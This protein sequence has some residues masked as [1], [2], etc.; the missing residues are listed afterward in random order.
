MSKNLPLSLGEKTGYGLG[1]FG[2]GLLFHTTSIYLLI[3]YTDV[4]GISAI[5][6]S[7]LFLVAR[8]WDAINDPIVGGIVDRTRS[9]WG[10]FRPYL[11]FGPIPLG[12]AGVLCFTV[13]DL[14]DVGKLIYAYVTY[15]TFGM[16][17]TLVAVPYSALTSSITMDSAERGALSGL[18]AMFTLMAGMLVA[19]L[20]LLVTAFGGEDTAGGYQKSIMLFSALM[21][22]CLFVTFYTTKERYSAPPQ[23]QAISLAEIISILKT[24]RPLQI[25][26]LAFVVSFGNMSI[27]GSVGTYFFTYNLGRPDLIPVFMLINVSTVFVG[28]LICQLVQKKLEKKQI[29]ILGTLIGMIRPLSMYFPDINIIL[30]GSVIGGIGQGFA[31]AV[32]WAFVADTIEYGQYKTGQ[33]NEGMTYA[34]V[35][36]FMKMGGALGAMIPGFVLNYTGYVP[37]VE[38]TELTLSGI[39]MLCATIPL[40]L[41]GCFALVM[42]RYPL[43]K[44]THDRIVCELEQ[45]QATVNV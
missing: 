34:L 25:V 2:I 3:F 36:F 39:T 5:A 42:S 16:I 33:R 31:V 8:L 18:R 37:N 20:P 17:Y 1:D 11:L 27:A 15:I 23:K 22:A 44:K 41:Y 12:I 7:T 32:I 45:R 14:S 35:G 30:T 19:S 9:S 29:I 43:D 4:F 38:Q 10:K 40:L 28:I 13:P 6:A 24:N 26:C 21:V